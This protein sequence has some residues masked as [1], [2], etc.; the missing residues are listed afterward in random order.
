MSVG[1]LLLVLFLLS[2][3]SEGAGRVPRDNA[4]TKF[5]LHHF[6][7]EAHSLGIINERQL[8]ELRGLAPAAVP[9][10]ERPEESARESYSQAFSEAFLH[11]YN[12]FSLLN[13]LYFSG[14][15]LVMG[16]FTLFSTLAWTNFGYGGV[17]LVL[18]VPLLL[19]GSLGVRLWEE[20]S[21]AVLGG[22]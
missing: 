10:S 1:C 18:L 5:N 20:G 13:V 19:T 14:S 4:G 16:A 11:A 17:T 2:G 22:L 7:E 8:A 21:Y 12:Q 3:A 15:L 9:S 6:L